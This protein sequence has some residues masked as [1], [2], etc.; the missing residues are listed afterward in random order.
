MGADSGFPPLYRKYAVVRFMEN[1]IGNVEDL[2][3]NP[4][5]CLG[6]D[7][8][9]IFAHLGLGRKNISPNNSDFSKIMSNLNKVF[10]KFQPIFL[11]MVEI[12]PSSSG[13]KTVE[14][15]NQNSGWG[16]GWIV[17]VCARLDINGIFYCVVSSTKAKKKVYLSI[18]CEKMLV[19]CYVCGYMGHTHLEDGDGNTTRTACNRAI[20]C[21]HLARACREEGRG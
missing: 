13:A 6:F 9:P 18:L 1:H 8:G 2:M 11:K 7:L 19:F 4:T 12:Q 10:V 5:W 14:N 20:G 16:D 17:R 21:W 3:L 15:Q